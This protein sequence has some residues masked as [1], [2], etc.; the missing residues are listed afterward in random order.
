[1]VKE[2]AAC[3]CFLSLLVVSKGS[4]SAALKA[5]FVVAGDGSGDF[6]TIQDAIDAVPDF[7]KQRTVI[8]V[9]P[10]V[11]EERLTLAS[12]KNKVSLIGE[13]PRTTI[14]A[15]S[16]HAK[17][18]N[19]F[20]EQVGTTGSSGFF[21]FGDDFTCRNFT[22]E[23]RAGPVGQAVAVRVD[24]D[25][26]FFENCRFIGNQDTLYPHGR[27][28]RQYYKN[29]Y[30]EGTVDFIFGWSTA[31]FEECEIFC[32]TSGYV[33]AASTEKGQ[34]YG[35]VFKNCRIVGDAA[36]DT[37][38]LGRPWRPYAKTVFIDCYM[39]DHIKAEGWHN[40]GKEAAEK[41]VFYA[42]Y[43]SVGPG[44]ASPEARVDWARTLAE[45]DLPLF[46]RSQVLGD[47]DLDT[48]DR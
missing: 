39:G 37:F 38:Y 19:R 31:F 29:C 1:M 27:D 9:K 28:S 16:M 23:N 14:V 8:L 13:D 22:F 2:L 15:T 21:L 34:T 36:E 7:R 25:R 33:T 18:L 40:W 6:T 42:E 43:G 12:T 45:E 11:Y 47:W 32:K 3:F 44:A 17:S 20:G 26:A 4:Q 30:I 41:T 48:V 5:D 35:F 46:E 10:G 24:G